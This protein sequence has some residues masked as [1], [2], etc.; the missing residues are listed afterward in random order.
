MSS[1]LVP[2]DSAELAVYPAINPQDLQGT[3]HRGC[4]SHLHPD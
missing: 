1:L 4:E 2:T 3:N